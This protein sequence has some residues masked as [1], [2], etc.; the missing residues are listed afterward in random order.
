MVGLG[1]RL[2]R[3]RRQAEQAPPAVREGL[4]KEEAAIVVGEALENQ[5]RDA[6]CQ[7]RMLE[8][9]QSL[10]AGRAGGINRR[11]EEMQ[12]ECRWQT[13]HARDRVLERLSPE[14]RAAFIAYV[15]S[16]KAGT[17]VTIAKR[18]LAHYR[19]PQ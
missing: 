14:G 17:K 10:S 3:D 11:Q 6:A 18:D 8:I 5:K 15:E 7:E 13:L 12:I 16:T 9:K 4:S 19:Q 2:S 1:I